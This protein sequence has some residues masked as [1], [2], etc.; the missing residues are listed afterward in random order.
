MLKRLKSVS[1][2]LFFM[3]VSAG[4]A[5]AVPNS[6]TAGVKITQQ[7]GTCTGVVVDAAGETVIGA[8]VVVKG[9]TNGTITGLDGDFSLTNVKRGDVIQISFVGYQTVEIAWNG[10]PLNVTLQDDTQTLQE[11][12]VTALGIKREKKALGY[13]MQEVK[14][15]ALVAARENNLANALT[16]KVSGVQVIRSSNG[17]AGSSKIQLRGSNSVTGTNQPLIVVDGVPMDN[18]LGAGNNDLFNPGTDMGNGLSDI[19]PED[20]ES[21]SVLKGASAAALYGSRAGNG[22]ILITTKKGSKSEGLG[23][24]LSASVS[25]ENVFMKPELQKSFGQGSNGI[26]N[27]TNGTNWGP[28]LDG[29]SY[30]DWE[31]KTRNFQYYDNMK[32]FF[33]TGTNLTESVSFSQQ[34]EKTAVYVSATRLDDASM[35]PGAKYSRTNLTTRIASTFGKDDRWSL[36]AKIQYINSLAK[37]RPISGS[38]GSNYFY[39]MYTLPNNLDIRDF[40]NCVNLEDGTMRWWAKGSSL[41]PYWSKDYNTNQD[42]RNRFLMNFSLKY[43]FTDW[44]NLELK[45]GSDMY[46]TETENKKYAG[47]PDVSRYQFSEQKFFE[48][49]FS[50]LI[51][52]QKDRFIADKIG[53]NVTFGGNLME[54]KQT[55]LNSGITSLTVPNLFWITNSAINDRTIGQQLTHR[56]MNSLYGT[57][58]VNYDGWLFLDGTFRNDWSSTLSK[59][60]RSFFYPS[61][62]ASWVISDMVNTV[63][64]GM[65]EWFTYAKARVSFAQVGNDLDPYRLYN[66]YSVGGIS[67]TEGFGGQMEGNT[68]YNADVRSELISSWE[69]GAELR[70]FNNRFGFD[71][72]WY[73][74]NA[75]RQLISLPLNSLS[76]YGS[77]MVNAGDIQNTGIELMIN[78]T[79]VQT[80]DF[81]WDTQINFSKNNNKVI[82]LAEGV[83]RYSLGNFYD[84]LGVWATAGGNY[85]EIWGTTFKRVEDQD[86]PYYGQLELNEAGLPQKV[87]EAKKIGD[88]QADFLLGWTNTFS[89]KGFTLS[90]LVDG[91]FGGDIMSGSN[92]VLQ[93]QGV[94]A[95]TAPNGKR[96]KF[97]V[98]GVI[99]SGDSYVPSTIEVTPQDYWMA[100]GQGNTGISEAN[101]YSATNIRLRNVSL[102]YTFSRSMLKNTPFQQIKLGLSCNN[103][104]MIKSHLHGIDPESVFAIN[105]NATG[106]ELMAPPT[107]RSFLFNVTLG[108]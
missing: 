62:S 9:T 70:F 21:M 13:A 84:N 24:T 46:F 95:V 48:N 28:A 66:T 52:A 88:Q 72:A 14:G 83:S 49:N 57:F 69:A 55:G 92:A 58:G 37:N 78:A 34:F 19:N 96:D 11:V 76:G 16:G 64:K 63:G 45:A 54:R 91:R 81:S 68:L 8:S 4:V 38:N 74:S 59:D 43:M 5:Y 42:S 102:N 47:S 6:G 31:G 18:F 90:F 97:V 77:K 60:N 67:Y 108:F 40:K 27:A 104:W 65:P 41:N 50:F 101:I 87:N 17:P 75:R 44:L 79:P 20:I 51:T 73:K 61:I 23:L 35:T 30:T 29:S 53:G 1:M 2:M 22:V 36:D 89:Y 15:D 105:S 12:V 85:G 86:S 33:N 26:F 99:K 71:F 100:V 107:T 3:G 39:A 25:V 10:Q 82:E 103:V 98:D 93:Q 7:S 56:K 106:V 32:N 94:A 80:K